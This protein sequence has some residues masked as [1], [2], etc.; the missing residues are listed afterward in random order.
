MTLIK[1]KRNERII[2]IIKILMNNEKM[3]LAEITKKAN[4]SLPKVTETINLMKESNIVIEIDSDNIAA[5]GRPSQKFKLNS[6]YGYFLGIDLGRIHTNFVVLDY[7]QKKIFENHI[8]TLLQLDTK[9]VANKLGI[10]INQILREVKIP[11]SKLM[12]IGVSIPGIVNSI[13][14]TSETYLK[15]EN[16]TIQEYFSEQFKNIVRIEHDV[17]SMALGEIYYGK[18]TDLK[19]ALYLNFGWGLGLGIIFN[20]ELYYGK[21]SYCGEFGHIPVIPNGELCYCGKIGCLETVS[22][23]RAITKKVRDKI[24]GGAS[25]MI[26][27]NITDPNKIEALDIL[28]AA[29]KGDQF[30]IEILE[31]AGKYLGIGIAMLINIFN[32]EKIIIGGTF[33]QVASY[34]LDIAKSNAMKHSLTQLNKN[35]QFQISSLSNSSGALGVARLTAIENC[36]K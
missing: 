22:S 16:K 30:S 31:E 19:N 23:G 1:Q 14:G 13:M 4:Q 34:I 3:T 6:A 18:Y 12:G 10:N 8:P 17:K 25:S 21:D 35:V 7:S 36:Y 33:T 32:P 2:E 24:S 11:K 28:K 15:L 5:M 20:G 29:N 26:L 27:N 9:E